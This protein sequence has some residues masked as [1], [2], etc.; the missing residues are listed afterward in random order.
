MD[1]A[2]TS[3]V[4]FVKK[5]E[6]SYSFSLRRSLFSASV[7]CL[8]PEEKCQVLDLAFSQSFPTRR[9]ILRNI[10]QDIKRQGF[11][12]CHR[13]LIH[14][15]AG[16]LDTL[17]YNKKQGCGHCLSYLYDCA[18]RDVQDYLL[19]V[20]LESKYVIVR[21]RAYKKLGIGWDDSYKDAIKGVW[22][23][24]H[25][26]DCARLIIDQFDVKYLNEHFFDLQERVEASWHSTKL[27]LRV[28]EIDSSKL[29]HLS[30]TDEITFAYVSA[31]L[32]KT[33]EAE[34]ALSM[35]ERNKHDERLGLLVWCFGQMKLWFVLKTIER[36]L[37]EEEIWRERLRQRGDDFSIS[38]SY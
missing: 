18:P 10:E 28:S 16:A 12:K 23:A 4:Q 6:E 19:S 37:D 21:R 30:Q 17:P 35:F 1:A 34:T 27:Y 5:L 14:N 29:E 32:G 36:D 11:R 25:D 15:L 3:K 9:I 31:K 38:E 20:F 22:N 24:H 33:F 8:T 7:A 26:A 2:S 13:I